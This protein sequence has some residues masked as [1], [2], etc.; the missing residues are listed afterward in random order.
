[1]KTT[2]KDI[3]PILLIVLAIV[4]LILDKEAWGWYVYLGVILHAVDK[5]DWYGTNES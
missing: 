5:I 1:M 2:I 3:V 4:M